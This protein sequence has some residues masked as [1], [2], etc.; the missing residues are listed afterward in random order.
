MVYGTVKRNVPLAKDDYL[1][2]D[3]DFEETGVMAEFLNDDERKLCQK[4]V[5]QSI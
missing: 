5:G 3:S 1:V 2:K 4:I